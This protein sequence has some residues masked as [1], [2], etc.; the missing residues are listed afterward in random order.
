M[1]GKREHGDPCT[2]V[3]FGA[4]GDL[5]KRKLIAA[6][7]DL[8][9]NRLLADRFRL[10]G[11]DRAP[12]AL[13][14]FRALMRQATEQSEE[15][16]GF[17]PATWAKFEER[18]HYASGDLTQESAYADLKAK[19][20]ELEE[21][22]PEEER[23]RL[24][25]LSVPPFVFSAIV[26][27]LS[28]SGLAPRRDHPDV[29]PWA[30]VVVEKPFGESLATARELSALVLASFAETQVYRIDHYLGKE[31]V[32]NILVFRAAN[33]IFEP[34]WNKE[35]IASVQ[36]TAAETVGVEQ[37]AKYY[38]RAGVV[39]D[40]VQNHLLQLL[41][42]TAMD[43]PVE[44]EAN[45][46]RDEKVKALRAIKPVDPVRD[47]VRAQYAAGAIKG[48]AVPAYTAEPGVEPTSVTPTYA[49]L[50]VELDCDRWR[51]VPFFIRSGKRMAKRVSEIAIQFKRPPYLMKGLTGPTT[52]LPVE[53]N[54]L[55]MRV[56][57]NDG[58]TLRFEAKIP[59]AAVALTPE[60]EVTSVDMDFT[61]NEAFNIALSPAYETLLLDAMIGDA[62]L[63]TRTDEV[64]AGW[65]LTDP[66]LDYWAKNPPEKLPTYEAGSWGP[67]EADAL[68]GRDGCAWRKP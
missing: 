35:H 21:G 45:Q 2:L 11:V 1:P 64:E 18:I 44:M 10:L 62:T 51:G 13:A 22:T 20:A 12:M 37:R 31:T 56:Q 34:L 42:L 19:V 39:R 65:H 24:F 55:V 7:F 53:P 68:L 47:I 6:L 61:Y 27:H 60:I 3:L 28:S 57:P 59:G 49:A 29:R 36:I 33:A 54:Q 25:Y 17:D 52:D 66:V 48:D 14:D 38:D 26:H 5:A 58:I 9:R 43:L 46:V 4:T 41:A 23:N 8:Y 16:H 50:R 40:M 63:F 30:R 32:Q 67:K 15:I